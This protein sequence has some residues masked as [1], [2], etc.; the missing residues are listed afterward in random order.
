[1]EKFFKNFYLELI[2]FGVVF[3]VLLIDLNPDFTFMNK[4]A[5]S[6]GYIYSASYLYP[7]YH[8]SPPLY[9]L[10]SHFF[11][12]LPFG[13]E[14]WRMGLVSLLSTMGV[15][16]F[17]YLTIRKLIPQNK[18]YVLAGVL[19]YGLSALVISQSIIVNTYA[20]TTMLASGAFY[21]AT[22]KHWKLMGLMLGIG[23]AVHLLAAFVFL[24]MLV[25][26]REY[27]KNWKALVITFS[28]VICYI[29]IPLTNR[30]PYMWL[31]DP[32]QTNT[33]WAT[34]TDTLSTINMLIGSLAIWDLPKR[35]IDIIGVI[36]VSIGVLTIVPLIYYFRH[37]KIWR[38]P[39]FWLIIIPILLF[40][41]ELD[42]NT[43]DYMMISMPFLTIVICLGFNELVKRYQFKA[44][45]FVCASMAV[46]VGFGV[47]NAYYF[48]IGKHL[49][50]DMSATKLYREEFVKLP[51]NAVFMPNYAW[52][53]EAIYKYSRDTGKNIYPICID[54]LPSE[55]YQ[56]QLMKDG[57][58]LIPNKEENSSL[59]ASGIAKSIVELNDNVWTTVS[60]DPRTFGSKVIN[61]KRDSSLVANIDVQR[62][63]QIKTN[64]QIQWIPYNPYQ[65]LDTSLFEIEWS[66]VL[67]STW[68]VK[69]FASWASIGLLIMW[70]MNW[71]GNKRAKSKEDKQIE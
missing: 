55:M 63:N 29:Y 12:M 8:T 44:Q 27:R 45:V 64:P 65:I 19:V 9:L 24:I 57:I 68:D 26:Y 1:M 41:G 7:S 43:Y 21:F 16:V 5:D 30:P 54:I 37:N 20:T 66:Y 39:L 48:D 3:A 32:Q 13:T 2:V 49:D 52:E 33:I 25:G 22:T 59:K 50:S 23:L 67:R 56:K 42:M 4:A 47:F 40:L 11:L 51:D 36:S 58:K 31:P 14:A 15:C 6:I 17:I 28:F 60:T 35:I 10:T 34:I 53:W 18:L 70:L 71:A 46:V 69:F 38:N 62:M 61:T